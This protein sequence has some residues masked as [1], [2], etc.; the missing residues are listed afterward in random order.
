MQ[1]NN[2]NGK[3]MTAIERAINEVGGQTAMARLLNIRPQSVQSWVSSGSVPIA[4]A[5]EVERATGGV[6]T[7]RELRPDI[8]DF[9]S[10]VVS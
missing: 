8:F 3:L 6:V 4:R 1:V 9:E 7:R 2:C 10:V 5:V